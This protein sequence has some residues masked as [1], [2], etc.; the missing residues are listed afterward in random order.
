MGIFT[1][2]TAFQEIIIQGQGSGEGFHWTM[3]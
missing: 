3:F 1:K 2:T